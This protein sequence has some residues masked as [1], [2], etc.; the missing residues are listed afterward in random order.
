MAAA[1]WV[2]QGGGRR[3][4]PE[5]EVLVTNG[6][7]QALTVC[8][9]ALLEPGDEVLLPSPSFF[10]GELIEMAGA[11]AGYVP[12]LP[13][14]GWRWDIEAMAGMIG[15][16]T[17]M[18]VACNPCNP[19]GYVPTREDLGRLAELAEAHDLLVLADES[20]ERFVFDGG[21][22]RPAA[23]LPQLADRLVLVRSVSKS[24]GMPGWRV[25]FVF[26]PAPLLDRCLTVFE[27]TSL[28]CSHVTQRAAW[29][30]LT[31]P[32]GWLDPV[33]AEYERNRAVAYSAAST[34]PLSCHLPAAC[35]FLFVDVSR[36]RGRDP[37]ERE[38][39]L[40]DLGIPVVPGRY[41]M[42]P[43]YV[44]LPFGGRPEALELLAQRLRD[45][46]PGDGDRRSSR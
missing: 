21:R 28:R 26:A 9:Q 2:E 15:P 1:A 42:W 14:E 11:H 16:R 43:D 5:T 17:R 23:M 45:L 32:T 33:L 30:A 44:R 29:A 3:F 34:A 20:Y 38:D 37:S 31:G 12:A 36:L 7:M 13:T 25:G 10:F 41:F 22:I 18:L 4:D 6:G 46:Q 8:F 24:F 19:T 39:R 40:L 27:W 35:P